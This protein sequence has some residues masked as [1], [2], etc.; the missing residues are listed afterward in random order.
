MYKRKQ[1]YFSL[2]N[3]ETINQKTRER[4]SLLH[5]Q[6]PSTPLAERQAQLGNP[7]SSQKPLQEIS[8]TWPGPAHLLLQVGL[9]D[10]LKGCLVKFDF[11]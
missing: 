11:R 10:N 9:P 3:K 6:W 8:P 5:G 1:L 4:V 7:V 2:G